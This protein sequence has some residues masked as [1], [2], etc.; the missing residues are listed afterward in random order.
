[1]HLDRADVILQRALDHGLELL[2]PLLAD[3]AA[4]GAGLLGRQV[5]LGN[6]AEGMV[7]DRDVALKTDPDFDLLF[8]G[9]VARDADIAGLERDRLIAVGLRELDAAVPVAMAHVGS[10]EEDKAGLDFFLVG[11][12]RHGKTLTLCR[13]RADRGAKSLI[14]RGWAGAVREKY[15]Q[16]V[17]KKKEINKYLSSRRR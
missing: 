8:V 4:L 7:E 9:E 11:H 6:G 17:Q 15:N 1:M 16:N 12:E 10:G 5:L 2:G 13:F 14:R 3:L